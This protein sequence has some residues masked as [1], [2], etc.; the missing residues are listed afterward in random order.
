[1]TRIFSVA[2]VLVCLAA[3]TALA[4]QP[5]FRAGTQIVPILAT[6]TDA[7]GRLV[8][9]LDREHF[10]LFDNGRPQEIA[11]FQNDV[12]PFTVVVMLDFSAS[13]TEHLGLLRN[14]AEQFLI[15][16]LPH[17]RAQVG[18]FSDKIQFSGTFTNDRDALIAALG[19]LQF[20][21][22]TLLY[23][24]IYE[25]I[26]ELDGIDG[27]RVVLVFTDGEDYGSSRNHRHVLDLARERDVMIYAIGLEVEY[28]NGARVV[29]TRP[30]RRLWSLAA[31]TGGGSFELKKTDE[32]A[33]TFTRVV[34]ELHSM[35]ML[36]FTPEQWDGREHRLEVRMKEP[37]MTARARRTYVATPTATE[38]P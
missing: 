18:A 27:R 20:G 22:K 29:R 9:F 21:N 4:Q 33:P 25:S 7:E 38:D 10:S 16:I 6:V 17:D 11:V 26:Q 32:L 2:V 8:P 35:Y 1:M 23:D 19:D 14:A 12:Q 13:M 34:Q 36:G 28:F 30:D 15:R 3:L 24:A 31:E 5:T 37:G